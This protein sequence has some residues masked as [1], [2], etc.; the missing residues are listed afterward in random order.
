MISNDVIH[1]Q[2]GEGGENDN[3]EG[4]NILEIDDCLF[5]VHNVW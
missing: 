2:A 1:V 4:I 3:A 5:M